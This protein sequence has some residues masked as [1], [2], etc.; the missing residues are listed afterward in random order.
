M[1]KVNEIFKELNGSQT[2]PRTRRYITP[3]RIIFTQGGVR[4][5]DV[6]LNE[7]PNQVAFHPQS[8]CEM[9]N[10]PGRENAG[11]LIDFGIEFVGC[12]RILCQGARTDNDNRADFRIRFGESVM[13]ALTPLGV[14]NSTN[15]H[16]NRDILMSISGMSA[17][18]TNESGFRFVYIELLGENAIAN[19]IGIKGVF[20]YNDVDYKGSFE[21]S[22]ERLNKIWQVAAYTVHLNM[23]EYL[24]D[25]IKRDRLV[26][27][28]DMHTEV[29]TILA[30]FGND[31]IIKRSLD[32]I[33]DDTPMTEWMNNITTY[34]LWWLY[35]HHDLYRQVGDLDYLMEQ[36]DYM[37]ALIKRI[38]PLVDENGSEILPERRFLDWP[39]DSY[40]E[41]K[42]AGL[43]GILKIVLE[44]SADL[45][46][47]FGETELADE[48]AAKA[49]LMKTHI[50]SP[51][52]SKQA[53]SMLALSRIVDA[54][55]VNE[56]WLAPGG[57]HGYS[58]F[59]GYYLLV[60]KAM[61]GDFAGAL[62]DIKEFWG[63]MLDMGAT[64][65]WEDFNLDWLENSAPIDE[66]V[67]EG[68]NDIHG[69]F[70]AYCYKNFRHSLCHGWS[71]GPCPYMTHYVLG[72]RAVSADTYEIDPELAYLD[73]AKG[74]YPTEKGMISVSAKKTPEGTLVE[75]SAPEGIKIIR[76]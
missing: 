26:W 63:A 71:S 17:N 51:G 38:L 76:K 13:E 19:L 27:I 58:T 10:A 23:Q 6:L 15:N 31:P 35:M 68:K 28:G 16:A 37:I 55:E 7:C 5:E 33:R 34:S 32:L 52:T 59:F 45:L 61:A 70:G 25:G 57:A 12:I 9:S 69:D 54:K 2:D 1:A 36:K 24:W 66:I 50:P 22:D 14:K 40:P 20:C 46:R 21:C 48:C 56:K 30:V 67:P 47:I 39:N 73:W 62:D 64:T 65:F 60:A 8:L 11:I 53:A 44:K 29:Q 75:V 43:Q 3:K 72:I 4:K 42:H 18:E 41:G 74:E 49:D